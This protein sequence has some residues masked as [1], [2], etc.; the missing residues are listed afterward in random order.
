M[1]GALTTSIVMVVAVVAINAIIGRALG[2]DS[3]E[4]SSKVFE[5]VLIIFI[6]YLVLVSLFGSNLEAA[7]VPFLHEL[8]RYSGLSEFFSQDPGG[9]V[10]ECA[11][12]I[13]LVFVIN[14]VSQLVPSSLGGEGLGGQ[15]LRSFV[16]VLAGLFVNHY[17]LV[18]VQGTPAFEWALT[19]LQCFL[20]GAALLITPAMVIGRM[21]GVSPDSGIVSFLVEKLPETGVG[22]ALS[23]AATN[24]LLLV[25]VIMMC[26]SQFGP[27]A[28]Y[29]SLTPTLVNLLAPLILMFGA[30]R[31]LFKTM[32]K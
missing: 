15:A 12:L 8:E 25:F 26:E 29:I 24:S 18:A 9:F 16:L 27:L 7:G 5:A 23:S 30:Y 19:A 22:K 13:S 4:G 17:V 28:S 32:L 21:I 11:K 1:V 6:L 10:I 3:A 20:S 31:I 2:V 14:L